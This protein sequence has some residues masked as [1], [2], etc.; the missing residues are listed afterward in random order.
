MEIQP[1][2]QEPTTPIS[3]LG[4]SHLLPQDILSPNLI[5]INSSALSSSIIPVIENVFLR[6]DANNDGGLTNQDLDLILKDRNKPIVGTNDPRDFDGDGKITIFDVRKLGL[7]IKGNTDNLAPNLSASLT[8]DT[9]PNNGTNTDFI[10]ADPAIQGTI[11][12]ASKITRFRAGFDNTPVDQFFNILGI[13]EADGSFALDAAALS[14]IN[15]DSLTDGSHT[16]YLQAQDKWGNLSSLFDVSFTLDTQSP[17]VDLA[18]FEVY[19]T[20]FDA[21]DIVYNESVSDSALIAGNYTLQYNNRKPVD[22]ISV[23]AINDTTVRV[24]LAETLIDGSYQLIINP[25]ISDLAGNSLIERTTF[26][27]GIFTQPS[28]ATRLTEISPANGEEMVNLTRETIIRFNEP[29]DPTTVDTDSFYLIA[30]GERVAGRIEVSSTE[31]FATFFY[32]N[33]LV[34]STEVRVVVDG[35]K[36]L[37]RNGLALDADADGLAGGI[38]TADFR[39]LPLTRIAGTDVWGYVYDSYNKNSD[40]SNIPVVGATIRVDA[41]PGV[42]AV[43]DENGYFILRD[44]PA[45]EFFVHI[46][47]STAVNAPAGTAYA[48]LGKP[49]H[50]V[51]GQST[52]LTMDGATFNIY[53]PPMAASDIQQLSATEETDVGFGEASKAQLQVLFPNLDPSIWELTKV[54]FSPGSARD[55]QGNAATQAAIIAVAPNRLPAPLPPNVDPKLIISIQA[56]GPNGFSQAGGA[57]RFDVPAP[58]QFPNLEGLAPGEK[59]LIWSFDHDAGKWVIIGNGTVSEDGKTIVSDPGVGII[60][61]GW[62]FTISG[63]TAKQRIGESKFNRCGLD[64]DSYNADFPIQNN[65]YEWKNK[66]PTLIENALLLDRILP[67]SVLEGAVRL[68]L[69]PAAGNLGSQMMNRFMSGEG[70]T[71]EQPDGS[72]LSNLIKDS[73]VFQGSLTEIKNDIQNKIQAQANGGGIDN[74]NIKIN[75]P[76]KRF[77]NFSDITLSLLVG[78][79]QG[80]QLFTEN[81]N[82]EVTSFTPFVGG[83]GEYSATLKF[84]LCDDFGVDR[85]DLYLPPLADLWILQHETVGTKSFQIKIIVEVPIQGNFIIPSGYEDFTIDIGNQKLLKNNTL[86]AQNIQESTALGFGSDPAVFYRYEMENGLELTGS[87]NPDTSP[88]NLVLAPNKFFTATFYQP[89]TNNSAKISGISS[90]S[91]QLT[92]FNE[93]GSQNEQSSF[94][95][96]DTF[97]GADADGDGIPDVGE[98]VLGSNPNSIDSDGDGIRDSA[99]LEQGLDPLNGRGFPTGIISTLPIRGEAKAVVVEG[100]TLITGSQTAYVATGSYGLAIVDASQFNNPI[101]LGQLDLLGDAT[102]VSVDANLKIAA[103]ATN[104]EGL[105]L[106]DVSDPML[107]TLL[108]TIKISANQVSFPVNQVEVV[109]GIAYIIAGTSLRTIDLLTGESL[110]NLTLPGFGTVTGLAREG[111]KLYAFTSGSDIFSVIDITQIGAARIVGQLSVSVA[112]QDVG[113]FAANGVAYLAGSGLRTINVS[114]PS[115]PTLISDADFFFTARDVALNGS[116]LALVAA[117]DQGIGVYD[118]SD[119]Q[120]TNNILFTVNTPGFAR[121]IAIAS[122][123]AFVADDTGGLQVIN[124][125]PF[126]NKGQAPTVSISSSVVDVDPN[127][128]GIQVNEGGNIPIRV[129]VA[130]DVQIRNVELLVNGEVVSNDVTL[131]FD[132]SAIALNNDPDAPVVN[133]QVRATDTGGNSS[134]SNLL[135]FDLVPDT[136]AP[137]IN[138]V[139]PANGQT[140]L[141]NLRRVTVR[142]SEALDTANVIAANFRLINSANEVIVPENIQLRESDRTVQLTYQALSAGSYQLI[143]DA[144]QITDRAGNPLGTENIISSFTLE[145]SQFIDISQTGNV[146]PN[147]QGDDLSSLVNLPFAFTFYGKTYTQA[148]I[149][150]NGLISFGGTNA[151]YVNQSLNFAASGLR[152]LPSLL[153]FWDDLET[154]SNEGRI[155]T[156]FTETQGSVGSRQ[157]II[158]WHQLEA[159][160]FEGETGDITFQVILTEGSN[161]IQ[162]NYLDVNFDGNTDQQNGAGRSATVGAWN[163]PTEFQQ[164]SF[165]EARLSDGLSLIVTEAGIIE[166]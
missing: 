49:F 133:V 89:S 115:N 153:P 108:R 139:T 78:G 55:D 128:P 122:G 61:P 140:T 166:S 90:S 116:G 33:P 88:Q 158:Q 126:D 34:P 79:L 130:D 25:A 66:P 149:S 77:Y 87:F 7:F 36:I 165:N 31:L 147:L 109:D 163:S 30:N 54:T 59:S 162:F 161:A 120:N 42:T 93:W 40:G 2:F 151:N 14:E 80:T 154:R 23:T 57:T 81:F 131:P 107:P 85:N 137:L 157:F 134:L 74:R 8:N 101:I 76:N 145:P 113:V 114:N 142:F 95:E 71:F 94:L 82:A 18:P 125:L 62:H 43:T 121:D 19:T 138:S 1:I 32:N 17:R 117:E 118:I 111:T 72:I 56:G 92:L 119:P 100:S 20:S 144:A 152:N 97:G 10:T 160:P 102:D 106:V 69:A 73:K 159:Y 99:E 67:S 38:A 112:S 110:Q 51:P 123:I 63:T 53:L 13:L 15:G 46:D 12:D 24:Y 103:V 86:E 22:I 29:I 3:D 41:L 35:N 104:S 5:N 155:A 127:T 68:F 6:G 96:F 132:L 27:F 156:V 136:V 135:A 164:Y 150:S 84:E 9:A 39:T 16:L 21:F 83:S 129:N 28:P 52:Q 37:G 11:I 50:S 44:M 124:Y 105:Q 148:G 48:T 70:G 26:D 75:T 143:I 64:S 47:G 141:E 45:P 146:V 65:L 91:G 98:F 60:A 58:I 4:K